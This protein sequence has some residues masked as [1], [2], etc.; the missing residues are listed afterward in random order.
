MCRYRSTAFASRDELS[1]RFSRMRCAITFMWDCPISW[2]WSDTLFHVSPFS[3]TTSTCGGTMFRNVGWIRV[4]KS[5]EKS[6][7]SHIVCG[8]IGGSAS[9]EKSS[10][11]PKFRGTIRGSASSEKS[12]WSHT[13]CGVIGDSVSSEKSFRIS[14]SL[15]VDA[16][17]HDLTESVKRRFDSWY[18]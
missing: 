2:G 15:L 11:S 6:F 1:S 12:S 9:S 3:L 18:T 7:R 4:S 17:H 10:R 8:T 5:S 16:H 14:N 13:D